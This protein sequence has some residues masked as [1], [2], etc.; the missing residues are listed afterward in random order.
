MEQIWDVLQIEPTKNI[1]EIKRA[2]AR[3]SK[4]I[5]PEEKPEEFQNLYEA[6]QR[7]LRYASYGTESEERKETGDKTAQ[8][9]D[10]ESLPEEENKYK[11]LGF[12]SEEMQKEWSH[13]E[14]A[15][16]FQNFW[17]KQISEREKGREFLSE[18]WKEYLQSEE[19][20]EIMLS[21]LVLETI[22]AGMTKYFQWK[23]DVLLFFWELYGFEIY[24]KWGEENFAWENPEG[25][26]LKQLYESLYP[27]CKRSIQRERLQNINFFLSCWKNQ[28][29]LW[30]RGGGYLDNNW[31]EY[32]QSEKFRDIMWSM[33]VLEAVTDGLLKTFPRREEMALF[34]W[35]L[36]GFR[37][38][39]KEK[40]EGKGQQLYRILYSA[41]VNYIKRQQYEEIREEVEKA[42]RKSIW[43]ML[44]I[45]FCSA[46]GIIA[47]M[48]I[49]AYFKMLD[50][51]LAGFFVAAVLVIGILLIRHLVWS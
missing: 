25:E 20:E 50:W 13:I 33:S 44:I 23:K 18:E 1:R 36:Y 24:E 16:Y 14:A 51:M 39:E 2:Y 32:L 10:E 35:E 12:Y 49:F 30:D 22:A 15:R 37:E 43:K 46:V 45:I 8:K 11:E 38:G 41:Y 26:G 7:A 34:F 4:E 21:P 42:E 48:F 3:R 6:Y 40:Y 19:F 29:L 17:N 27:V 28:L 31:K 5:H 9:A 47:F